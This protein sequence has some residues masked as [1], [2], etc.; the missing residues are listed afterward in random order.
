[1][2]DRSHLVEV[3]L[4]GGKGTGGAHVFARRGIIEHRL[5]VL[6]A[7]PLGI[8]DDPGAVEAGVDVGR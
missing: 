2:V 1:M 6:P 5:E 4:G 7:A 3:R 8:V